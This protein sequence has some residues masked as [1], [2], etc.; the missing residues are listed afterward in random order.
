M[1]KR[2]SLILMSAVVLGQLAWLGYN[3]HAR[4]E[5]IAEASTLNVVCDALDPRDIFRGDYVQFVCRFN[6]P[7]TSPLF[8]DLLYWD[9]EYGPKSRGD[10]GDDVVNVWVEGENGRMERR[11]IKAED[12]VGIPARAASN[13]GAI[14]VYYQYNRYLRDLAGYWRVNKQGPAT[15]V[16]VVKAGSEL[17]VPRPGELRTAMDGNINNGVEYA[18]GKYKVK[19]T[20][21]LKLCVGDYNSSCYFRFYVPEKTGEPRTAWQE[22]QMARKGILNE[23]K[24]FPLERIVTT[25]DFACRGR[26]G[27]IVKQLYLNNIPWVEAIELMRTGSFPLLEATK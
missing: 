21:T 8:S 17:D 26:N 24:P 22:G 4:T 20:V 27:L 5:E 9:E 1:K 10:D 25:V 14:G 18:D 7:L 23:G 15:L 13:D 11:E 2:L 19:A 3:Y 12:V 16:R 6:H